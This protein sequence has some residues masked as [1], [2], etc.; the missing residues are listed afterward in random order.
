[1]PNDVLSLDACEDSKPAGA[2]LVVGVRPEQVWP[3]ICPCQHAAV[4]HTAKQV[5]SCAYCRRP[6]AK[7]LAERCLSSWYAQT[8]PV[9]SCGSVR[10]KGSSIT[11]ERPNAVGV[12][13]WDLC[14]SM[15]AAHACPCMACA[16]ALACPAA[17]TRPVP[18]TL[19]LA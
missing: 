4:R 11:R 18:F 14:A 12:G 9:R 5:A 3:R 13:V 19:N 7:L 17:L 10:R 16:A 1:V 8:V 2:L 6:V 15:P